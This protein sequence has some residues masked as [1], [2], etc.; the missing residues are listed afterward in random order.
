M[1]YFSFSL[2]LLLF[3][4]G[5]Q[6]LEQKG[7]LMKTT[8]Y[9]LRATA[10]ADPSSG[11]VTPGLLAGGTEVLVLTLPTAPGAELEYKENGFS[12]WAWVFGGDGGKTQWEFKMKTGEGT[13]EMK[14]KGTA[15]LTIKTDKDT[16]SV[17]KE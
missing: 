13:A 9:G 16:I 4:A 1:K 12:F 3:L 14:S 2:L 10:G 8:L 6:S 17:I 7:V 5:C 15:D 11:A